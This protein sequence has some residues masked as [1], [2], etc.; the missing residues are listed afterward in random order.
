MRLFRSLVTAIQSLWDYKGRTTLAVL[1]MLVSTLLLSFLLS[2]LYNFKIGVEGQIQG[3]GL[4]Q[5]V[6]I[7]G[8]LLNKRFAQADLSSLMSITTMNSP[9]TY[10]DAIN[11][12]KHVS[13]VVAAVPQ[14]EI[15]ASAHYR[16]ISTDTLYTGTTPDFSKVFRLALSEGRWLDYSD[17]KNEAQSIVLGAQ[18]KHDLFGNARALGKTVS[19]KGVTFTVV[20]VLAPKQLIGFN[21]DERTYTEYPMILDTTSVQHASMIFFTIDDESHIQ[22]ATGQIYG[23]LNGDHGGSEGFTLVKADQ[24]LHFFDLL[25]KL[26]TAVTVGIASVSFFVGGIGIMNVML[27]V[28]KERTREIGLRK[29]VGAKSHQILAQ[30]LLEAL[31]I[32]LFGAITGLVASY[33]LINLLGA[34]FPTMTTQLPQYASEL[35]VEFSLVSGLVFGLIPA[36]KAVRVMPVDALRYE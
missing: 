7:P 18:T 4:K 26:L 14:T 8:Q 22:Q 32:S 34:Y 16:N 3:F 17:L 25:M 5:I 6:A 21:F 33:G 15:V 10:Q 23:V 28:V 27:L 24:A 2:V 9:L 13:D 1:G 35:S 29:A 20:G 11:V 12:K 36:I 31:I 19:I 30:F